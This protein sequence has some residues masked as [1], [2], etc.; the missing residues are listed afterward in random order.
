MAA[1][2]TKGQPASPVRCRDH[3]LP[4]RS[5]GDAPITRR[6]RDSE[7]FG[8]SDVAGVMRREVLAKPPDARHKEI[9][10]PVPDRHIKS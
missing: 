3:A 1:T 8:E 2:Q 10:G 9:V 7:E 5:P 6:E 4:I